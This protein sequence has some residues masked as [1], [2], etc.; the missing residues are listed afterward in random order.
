[1]I[2]RAS[3]ADKHPGDI[4]RLSG[5]RRPKEVVAA[6]RAAKAAAKEMAAAA[7]ETGIEKVAHIENKARKSQ[8]TNLQAN[9]FNDSDKINIPRV[10]RPRKPVD[11]KGENLIVIWRY[12]LKHQ[13][14]RR[15]P[16]GPRHWC[17]RPGKRY[18]AR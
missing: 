15:C 5:A 14:R 7:K 9:H 12:C 3:N 4:Q 8:S 2:T 11:D 17:D 1:M 16:P 6:E 10:R 13:P 18:I